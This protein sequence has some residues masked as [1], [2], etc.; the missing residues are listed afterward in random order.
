MEAE[1]DA[2]K[3]VE[4]IGKE[5]TLDPTTDIHAF[6]AQLSLFINQLINRDFSQLVFL[7]YRL[8]IDEK[9]LKD[10]LSLENGEDAGSII[11]KL[12][13]ERQLQKIKSRREFRR[14]Y[15]IDESE[16]W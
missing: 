6:L 16:K 7:L 11:S 4:I 1:L 9:K 8:D 5:L 10:I 15:D 13:F 12:I 2:R 14:D 3:A